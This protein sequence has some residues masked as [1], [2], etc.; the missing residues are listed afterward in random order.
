ML[1]AIISDGAIWFS[2][3]ALAGSIYFIVQL[4]M[5]HLGGDVDLDLDG[6]AETTIDD[7]A[8]EIRVLSLQSL[9]AFAIGAGWMG[10]AAYRLGGLSFAGSAVVAVLSGLASAWL[11]V[12]VLR[13]LFGLQ[14]SGNV[15]IQSAV[16]LTGELEVAVPPA[17]TGAGRV[18][19]VIGS[20]QREFSAV[21]RGGSLL[22]DN[23][24][25]RITA[26]DP[27]SNTVTVEQ[28]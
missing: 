18:R 3:P 22:H 14:S 20:S 11:L 12:S 17:G 26:A 6:S 7:P 9:S 8:G 27:A 2:A 21:Q 4:V 28:A 1:S 19:V 5:G 15:T 24:L 25:V 10:L 16:G 23:A 13:W